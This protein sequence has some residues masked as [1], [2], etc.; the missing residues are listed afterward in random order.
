MVFLFIRQ[1][2]LNLDVITAFKAF[3]VC[4]VVGI[5]K[6]TGADF[7]LDRQTAMIV[8]APEQIFYFEVAGY[9]NLLTA[10]HDIV[11]QH[12]PQNDEARGADRKSTR[13]NSSHVKISYAVFCLKRT[14]AWRKS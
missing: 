8:V 6:N 10:Y 2:V 9:K 12:I 7:T 13:L 5:D 14:S 3:V 1:Q 11:R 4:S